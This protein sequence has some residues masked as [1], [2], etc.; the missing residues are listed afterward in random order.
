M[1]KFNPSAAKLIAVESFF[2]NHRPITAH[3][4]KDLEKL[5][6][7]AA[8]IPGMQVKDYLTALVDENKIRVEKIGSGN[9]YWCFKGDEKKKK[10]NELKGCEKEA[11]ALEGK[12]HDLK[13]EINREKEQKEGQDAEKAERASRVDEIQRLTEEKSALEKELASY[14]DNDPAQIEHMKELM[15]LMKTAANVHTDN[16]YVIEAFMKQAGMLS[17]DIT[18]FK[19]SLGIPEEIE[20]IE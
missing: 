9:W 16:I 3:S 19:D 7:T 13:S 14:A 5:L 20:D 12:T 8:G 15:L 1:P 4:I 17:C 18:A 6:P 11:R 2:I 10:E